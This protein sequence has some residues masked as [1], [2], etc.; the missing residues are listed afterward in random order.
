MAGIALD[1]DE[2]GCRSEGGLPALTLTY[3][4]MESNTTIFVMV[5]FQQSK[6]ADKN[7]SR[8]VTRELM[9]L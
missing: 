6:N 9:L 3:V 4:V 2:G 1:E 8:Q 5:V 7:K